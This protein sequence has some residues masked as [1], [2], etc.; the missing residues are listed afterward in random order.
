L[1]TIVL[2]GLALGITAFIGLLIHHGMGDILAAVG[3]AGWG[4][5][6]VAAFHLVPLIMG[7]APAHRES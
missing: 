6:A 4:L 7:M 1:R 5:A 3:A 2:I